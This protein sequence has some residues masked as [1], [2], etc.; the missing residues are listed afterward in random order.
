MAQRLEERE[1]HE[2]PQCGI[3]YLKVALHRDSPGQFPGRH[4]VIHVEVPDADVGDPA[5]FEEAVAHHVARSLGRGEPFDFAFT[6]VQVPLFMGDPGFTG[7]DPVEDF[8]SLLRQRLD[9]G[10]V[11][12]ASIASDSAI[13]V[14]RNLMH[15]LSETGF[16]AQI[17]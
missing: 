13:P 16:V 10:R 1:R 3:R 2:V 6:C 7:F 8:G 12:Y 15:M 17:A 9:N 4:F 14:R 11:G 5:L